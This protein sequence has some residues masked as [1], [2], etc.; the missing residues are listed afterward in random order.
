M[1]ESGFF[2][3]YKYSMDYIYNTHTPSFIFFLF[4]LKTKLRQDSGWQLCPYCCPTT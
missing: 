3:F 4:F 1:G 2:E